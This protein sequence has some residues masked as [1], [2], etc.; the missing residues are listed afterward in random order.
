MYRKTYALIDC[1]VI[2]DNVKAIIK[3]YSSYKYYFGVVK[4]NAYGHGLGV[5]KYMLKAG[6][7]YLAVATLEEGLE[8]RK[9]YSDVPVLVLEPVS[10]SDAEVASK[11]NITITID[12][13]DIFDEIKKK[14]IRVKFHLKIDT[15]MNRF[16]VKSSEVASYI[17]NNSDK[18]LYM[19]GVFTQLYSGVG[20]ELNKEVSRFKDI[21]KDIDLNKVDIVHLD[22]SLTMEQHKAFDFANGVRLGVVMYG[23]AKRS[24]PLTWK[25]KLFN[26]L[27]FKKYVPDVSPLK[28]NTAFKFVTN[29][30]E[31]KEIKP[32]EG[33]GYGGMYDA[34]SNI[35]IGILPYGFADFALIKPYYVEIKG[36]KYKTITNYMD[37]T[38][39]IIDEDVKLGDEVII[40]GDMIGIR[41]IAGYTGVNVYKLICSVT[42]RVPRVYVYNGKRIEDE[43]V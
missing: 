33:V 35:K 26:K 12:N 2:E 30:M 7:N 36:K 34:K 5:I 22:R 27:T 10:A 21:T 1:N 9:R 15:G 19:E 23:F 40:F 37:I 17:Y 39:V 38:S 20:E 24:F 3:E 28:L 41:E 6:I 29:V 31:I 43:E 18:N 14:K 42:Y 32:G 25:R 13:K 11:N 4:A 8:V 16:G